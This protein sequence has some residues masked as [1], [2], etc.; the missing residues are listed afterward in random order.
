[1]LAAFAVYDGRAGTIGGK[2]V[3]RWLGEKPDWIGP[4]HFG[5]LSVLDLGDDMREVAA[6]EWLVGCNIAFD[7]KAVIDAGG[8][9]KSL[10]R[11]GTG[12]AL[13][14]NEELELTRRIKATGRLEIYNP[15]ACVEHVIPPERLTQAWFR[16]RAAWQAASDFITNEKDMGDAVEASADRLERHI[17]A[18]ASKKP[19]GF[20]DE[21]VAAE[22]F[23]ADMEIIYDLVIVSLNG[24]VVRDL[25]K[26]GRRSFVSDFLGSLVRPWHAK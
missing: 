25:K 13:L 7:R 2:V 16:R 14:S 15:K 12:L 8:F 20:F 6:G 23:A 18:Q 17:L 5:Y 21:K 3:P 24:G 22:Q 4:H 1:M 11:T 26:T 9:S 10:G 19:P